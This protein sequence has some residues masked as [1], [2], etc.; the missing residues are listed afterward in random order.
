MPADGSLLYEHAA[1]SAATLPARAEAVRTDLQK[2]VRFCTWVD[3]LNVGEPTANNDNAQLFSAPLRYTGTTTVHG[4]KHTCPSGSSCATPDQSQWPQ[5][6]KLWREAGAA[7][8]EGAQRIRQD[9]T[10]CLLAGWDTVC[11]L[12]VQ[13]QLDY[14]AWSDKYAATFQ[15]YASQPLTTG[16]VA[17]S[18]VGGLL[19]SEVLAPLK[20]IAAAYAKLDP[21]H[22]YNSRNSTLGIDIWV[23]QAK[24]MQATLSDD[25]A[26]LNH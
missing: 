14:Q 10:P 25:L 9:K 19:E 4:V 20:P 16:V 22:K 11:N 2:L 1:A 6:A 21:K 8:A 23:A 18:Y 5:I 12:V 3:T 7:T 17:V 24:Q 15:A 26:A 13:E